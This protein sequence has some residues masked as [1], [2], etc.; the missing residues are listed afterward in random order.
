MNEWTH[1]FIKICFSHTLF[2]K[3]FMFLWCVRDEWRNIYPERGLLLPISSSRSLGVPTLASSCLLVRDASGRLRVPRSTVILCTVSKS[4]RVVLITSSPSGYTPA[5]SELTSLM[6]SSSCLLIKIW[7]LA[8][9]HGVTR[10]E[11]KIYVICY[12]TSVF[13]EKL[14]CKISFSI[15][16]ENWCNT[17]FISPIWI[18]I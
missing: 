16:L 1:F 15:L 8:K 12:I 14:K 3:G 17:I 13:K 18:T 7:Q 2:L 4:D 6:L 9:A 5:W 10:N 11:P